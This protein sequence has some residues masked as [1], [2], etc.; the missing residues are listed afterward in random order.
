MGA[1][2]RARDPRG[3]RPAPHNGVRSP[4][5]PAGGG[6]GSAAAAPAVRVSVPPGAGARRWQARVRALADRGTRAAE[7]A[8]VIEGIRAV[9]AAAEAG[10]EFEA[11]ILCPERLRSEVARRAAGDLGARGVPRV[12]LSPAQFARLSAMDNPVG[13]MAVV[14]WS[15]LA[16]AE[17]AP[18]V[19]GA[20]YVIAEDL[21]DPGNLGTL[22]RT[23]DGAGA[24]AAIVAGSGTDPAHRR[25]LRA[26]LGTAFRLPVAAAPDGPAAL[27][28]ARQHG[29]TTVATSERAGATLWD[30][31]GNL[32]G[33][34]AVVLGN[35]ERGLRA[36][37]EAACDLAVSIPM[38]GSATS[39]N[40]GVAGGIVLYELCRV[41]R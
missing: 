4:A 22:L 34:I 16:L 29:V 13:L 11:V 25:C 15:P 8:C 1:R 39:L 3:R 7:G 40:V 17:L 20:V 5:G 24:A 23:A 21:A 37:T 35:E 9:L 32:R 12:E 28:W 36:E 30:P 6:R 33:A 18:P 10:L 19:P 26:S 31:P 2:Q 27:A 14:R 41:R 38:H